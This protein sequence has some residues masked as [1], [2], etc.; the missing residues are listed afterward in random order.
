MDLPRKD[1]NSSRPSSDSQNW[2]NHF[3][4]DTT[5][6]THHDRP[7]GVLFHV[8][9]AMLD[10]ECVR[11]SIYY[12]IP[13]SYPSVLLYHNSIDLRSIDLVRSNPVDQVGI[14]SLSR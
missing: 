6:H 1:S 5:V 11:L 10:K 14:E 2:H 4:H 3:R 9:G 12:P 8:S 13:Y 7:L